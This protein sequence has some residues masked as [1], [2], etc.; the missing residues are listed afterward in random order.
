[1][2][3]NSGWP[4]QLLAASDDARN[5]GDR[6]RPP[7]APCRPSRGSGTE[8]GRRD[9][10]VALAQGREAEGIVL[11]RVLVVARPGWSSSSSS[12]TTVASD[13]ARGSAAAPHI[14]INAAPDARE[15]L[16]ERDQPVVL[17]R[18]A[19]LAPARVV[20]VLLA[21]ARVRPVAWMWPFGEGQ[22]QTSVHAGGDRKRVDSGSLGLLRDRRAVRADVLEAPAPPS[23]GDPR[24][25]V[26]HMAKSAA[27]RRLFRLG[28]GA[29]IRLRHGGPIPDRASAQPRFEPR[30]ARVLLTR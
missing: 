7:R 17:R 15:R 6:A 2:Y 18:V 20:A 19:H 13:L 16:G 26:A 14:A 23:P 3:W 22:I 10:D 24:L 12:R 8:P 11:A 9:V 27:P 21:T 5:A 1:M 4:G 30:I 25:L 28:A 29:A